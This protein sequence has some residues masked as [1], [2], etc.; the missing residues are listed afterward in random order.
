MLAQRGRFVIDFWGEDKGSYLDPKTLSV[1]VVTAHSTGVQH[2]KEFTML[3]PKP[4]DHIKHELQAAVA[5]DSD[6]SLDGHMAEL[7][8]LQITRQPTPL[9][10]APSPW[11]WECQGVSEAVRRALDRHARDLQAR[12]LAS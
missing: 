2:P 1:L 9:F 7:D 5:R 3:E 6:P 4:A 10:R 8:A 12:F 11:D